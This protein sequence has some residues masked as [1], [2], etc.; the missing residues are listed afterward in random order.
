VG[1]LT[2]GLSSSQQVNDLGPLRPE[3]HHWPCH[4]KLIL[5]EHLAPVNYYSVQML[6]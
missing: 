3:L 5:A 6:L 4:Q 1:S 2:A